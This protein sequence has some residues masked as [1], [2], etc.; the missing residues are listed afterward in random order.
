MVTNDGTII[1]IKHDILCEVAKLVFAGKFE[2]EKDELPYRMMPGPKA[3][4]RQ[5][6]RAHV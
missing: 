1:Q 4:Y 6:G 5:I 3:K 2:T